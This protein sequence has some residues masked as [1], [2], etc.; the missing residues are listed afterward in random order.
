[1]TDLDARF[2]AI[3]ADVRAQAQTLRRSLGQRFRKTQG[4]RAA[5]FYELRVR[6]GRV[7]YG[8]RK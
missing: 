7:R 6:Y 3:L 8:R 2:D 4:D 1:M 5:R